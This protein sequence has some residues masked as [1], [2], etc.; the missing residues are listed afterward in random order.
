MTA[1]GGA[2]GS[3]ETLRDGRV[4]V[5]RPLRAV[6]ADVRIRM[7]GVSHTFVYPAG[8][9]ASTSLALPSS[10]SASARASPGESST[11]ADSCL[12]RAT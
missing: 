1:A 2:A 10:L 12:L 8:L 9:A 11:R 6:V 7:A 5:V 3:E 4:V